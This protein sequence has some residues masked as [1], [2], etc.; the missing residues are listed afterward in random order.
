MLKE[1][2]SPSIP[3]WFYPSKFSHSSGSL[4]VSLLS[5]DPHLRPTANEVLKHKWIKGVSSSNSNS[6]SRDNNETAAVVAAGLEV[7]RGYENASSVYNKYST[8][9]ANI[10]INLDNL[11]IDPINLSHKLNAS[12][13]KNKLSKAKKH[14]H[15]SSKTNLT[16]VSDS[17]NNNH[18]TGHSNSSSNSSSNSG[19]GSGSERSISPTII[20]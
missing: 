11:D 14:S 1:G 2:K 4:I 9:E 12:S 3:S 5:P 7:N 19:G 15:S 13:P 16:V 10:S 6:S 8:V 18:L 17:L 20:S